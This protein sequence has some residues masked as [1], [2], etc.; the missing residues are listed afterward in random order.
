VTKRACTPTPALEQLTTAE[1]AQLLTELLLAN[2]DLFGSR[3]SDLWTLSHTIRTTSP[4][5]WA[6]RSDFN[7]YPCT[8]SRPA[9]MRALWPGS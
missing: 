5:S 4:R 2:P 7:D 1:R 8:W 3:S 9:W 6:P